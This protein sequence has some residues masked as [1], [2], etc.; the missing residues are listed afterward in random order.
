MKTILTILALVG[1]NA[2]APQAYPVGLPNPLDE[3]GTAEGTVE[4]LH[5]DNIRAI[6]HNY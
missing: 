4:E 5:R 3:P 6:I 1:L 2:C